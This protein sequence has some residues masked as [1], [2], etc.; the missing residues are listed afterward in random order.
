MNVEKHEYEKIT[1]K[2]VLSK[3]DFTRLTLYRVN[4]Q[5][6]EL[7]CIKNQHRNCFK[8]EFKG[9]RHFKTY[10]YEITGAKT[11][12]DIDSLTTDQ[13]IKLFMKTADGPEEFKKLI[14]VFQI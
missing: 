1:Q 13:K 4:K 14:K 2:N 5:A 9:W 12:K 10:L 7:K 8:K 3:E 11:F 6:N